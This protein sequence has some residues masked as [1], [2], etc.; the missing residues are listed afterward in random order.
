M[1]DML[2]AACFE[3]VR[4]DELHSIRGFLD[5]PRMYILQTPD[6]KVVQGMG[7][8][9]RLELSYPRLPG[10]LLISY[11]TSH[12]YGEQPLEPC[13]VESF[14]SVRK[15]RLRSIL[16]EQSISLALWYDPCEYWEYDVLNKAQVT[17]LTNPYRPDFKRLIR[18]LLESSSVIDGFYV[19]VPLEHAELVHSNIYTYLF[20][21]LAIRPF[22]SVIIPESP[23]AD[24]YE[25]T[26][27]RVLQVWE[28]WAVCGHRVVQAGGWFEMEVARLCAESCPELSLSLSEVARVMFENASPYMTPRTRWVKFLHGWHQGERLVIDASTRD[29]PTCRLQA[30]CQHLESLGQK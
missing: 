18:Y 19:V 4:Y 13:L 12:E 25:R 22:A 15:A 26:I 3:I 6:F 8:R 2:I 1:A 21:N 11:K 17:L 10:A 7:V 24:V 29:E 20:A 9:A 28:A 14:I 16:A 5:K 30:A 27:L 23:V